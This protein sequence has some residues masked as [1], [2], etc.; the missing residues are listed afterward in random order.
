MLGALEDSDRPPG[1]CSGSESGDTAGG[2]CNNVAPSTGGESTRNGLSQP[3]RSSS[4]SECSLGHEPWLLLDVAAAEPEPAEC[5]QQRSK[6]H[7]KYMI[8]L[9]THKN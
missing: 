3:S 1:L 2:P 6:T 9:Y 7:H 8:V 5:L 4:S